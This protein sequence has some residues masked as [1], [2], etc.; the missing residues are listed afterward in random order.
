M[1]I[2]NLDLVRG[3]YEKFARRDIPGGLQFFNDQVEFHQSSLLP[4]GGTCRGPSQAKEFFA[5]L[6]QHIDSQVELVQLVKA[7][8]H[9]VAIGRLHGVTRQRHNPFDLTA[10]HVWTL[11]DSKAIRFEGYIDTPSMLAALAA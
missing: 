4:W 10:V 6:L 8:D 11:N 1:R 3:S 7:G 9:V 2:A 5:R